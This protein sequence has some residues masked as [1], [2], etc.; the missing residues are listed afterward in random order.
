M[1]AIVLKTVMDAIGTTLT[2]G[3]VSKRVFPYP[4]EQAE[5]PCAIVGYPETIEFDTVYARGSDSA[6]FPIWLLVGV[7]AGKASRDAL[8]D[9]ITGAAAVKNVLDG[10]LGGVVQTARVI[11][12]QPDRV[13]LDAVTYLAAR[14]DLEVLS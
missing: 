2:A 8:S 1:S 6:T 5:V 7:V 11:E 9:I 4:V 10:T 14:F 3:G 12:C 13:T